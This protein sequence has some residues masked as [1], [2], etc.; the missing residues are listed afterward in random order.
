MAKRRGFFARI[1]SAVSGAV[2]RVDR[3]IG[4]VIGREPP[5]PAPPP[6]PPMP[7]E[8]EPVARKARRSAA[9]REL[10]EFG[11]RED[12]LE[13]LRTMLDHGGDHVLRFLLDGDVSPKGDGTD[14]PMQRWITYVGSPRVLVRKLLW[15]AQEAE[16]LELTATPL[17]RQIEDEIRPL[18][19]SDRVTLADGSTVAGDGEHQERKNAPRGM[20]RRG[21]R[22]KK[23]RGS[24]T[25]E[26]WKK[27]QN[28]EKS[29]RRRDRER[30]AKHQKVL[31]TRGP[32]AAAEWKRKS[33]A[34]RARA[35][36]SAK[37]R[38][39]KT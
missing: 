6:V 19:E 32:K 26:S 39:G 13:T 30:Q 20:N 35:R 18:W 1:K 7:V 15:H 4:R 12:I 2:D 14:R 31:E 34:A 27:K 8:R 17:D 21:G 37:T 28:R 33:D 36:K 3:A 38:K 10:E 11:V 5:P 16:I 23:N 9:L 22:P 24:H 25:R 29:A